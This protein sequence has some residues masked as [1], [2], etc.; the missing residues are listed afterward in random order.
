MSPTTRL[1][2]SIHLVANA[3]L[4]WLAYEWLAMSES[5][6]VRLLWSALL[7]LL[8][9]AAASLLHGA[10]FTSFRK[11]V[12]PGVGPAFRTAL[13]HLLPVLVVVAAAIALY[14]FL[15]WWAGYSVI[16]TA[17]LA[18]WLTLQFR[19]PVRPATVLS[20]FNAVLWMVRWALLP[21][22]LLPL[23][24]GVAARGWRGI[25]EFGWRRYSRLYRL[26]VPL[27][28]LCAVW[29]PLRLLNWVPKVKGFNMEMASFG[30]RVA[31][32]YVL[33][34]GAAMVLAYLTSRGR[35]AEVG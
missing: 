19:K 22:E 1:F 27:L 32:A 16:P 9:L 20:C 30:L 4:L 5:S 18:S 8:I 12:A 28:T 2:C 35:Q 21:A 34:V 26:E 10:T 14:G 31:G 33:F 23:F 7:A 6:T 15:E 13:R 17:K 3:L 25:D 11:G 29:I 24:S